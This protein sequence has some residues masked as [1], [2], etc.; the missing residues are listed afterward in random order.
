MIVVE[1][2]CYSPACNSAGMSLLLVCEN[3]KH[4]SILLDQ[5][6]QFSLLHKHV[7]EVTAALPDM[8]IE[9]ELCFLLLNS[10]HL[11]V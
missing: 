6:T 11:T 10:K 5:Q 9:L 1:P 4:G 3:Q 8:W 7:A 2:R